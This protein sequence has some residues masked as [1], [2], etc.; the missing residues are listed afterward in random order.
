MTATRARQSDLAQIHIAKKALGLDDAA[1]R[2]ILWTVARVESSKDLDDAGRQRLL[3]HFKLCGWAPSKPKS[4]LAK[5]PTGRK[6]LHLWGTLKKQG[7]VRD[8]RDGATEKF[9]LET[10]K[11][12]HL[13]FMDSARW[14]VVI[15]AL[16]AWEARS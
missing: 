13:R 1:Y 10:A 12:S 9:V 8:G 2:D 3:A 14:S 5:T 7:K 16:K 4:E 15:E 11:V 6:C